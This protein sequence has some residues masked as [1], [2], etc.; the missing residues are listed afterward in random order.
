MILFTLT[1]T[2]NNTI[3]MLINIQQIIMT[4]QPIRQ[5]EVQHGMVNIY[6]LESTYVCCVAIN[7]II[8]LYHAYIERIFVY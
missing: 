6:I 3:T 8:N 4:Q 5:Q 1:Q 7:A 2:S